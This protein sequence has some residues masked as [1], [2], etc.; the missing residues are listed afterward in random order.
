MQYKSKRKK[1]V[2]GLKVFNLFDATVCKAH[3]TFDA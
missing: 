3:Q 1:E 2:W